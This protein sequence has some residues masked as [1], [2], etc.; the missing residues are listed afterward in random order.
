[1][2][3]LSKNQKIFGLVVLG[4]TIIA[5]LAWY[6]TQPRAVPI[7]FGFTWIGPATVQG[8]YATGITITDQ[9]LRLL[10]FQHTTVVQNLD[11]LEDPPSMFTGGSWY[12][13]SLPDSAL[14]VF[15]VSADGKT[16]LH[17]V[18]GVLTVSNDPQFCDPQKVNGCG[19]FGA[20][21]VLAP[22]MDNKLAWM[23]IVPG[24]KQSIMVQH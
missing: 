12:F 10:D 22:G 16:V 17:K 4:L 3:T 24:D 6:T 15:V 8:G 18:P 13:R 20:V 14:T 9:N 11:K 21:Y 23:L 1:M 7:P 5:S 19:S 2:K